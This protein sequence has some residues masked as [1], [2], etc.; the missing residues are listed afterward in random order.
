MAWAISYSLR[1]LIIGSEQL[2]AVAHDGE[3]KHHRFK[4][5]QFC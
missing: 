1:A 4:L 3:F 5:L 2:Y